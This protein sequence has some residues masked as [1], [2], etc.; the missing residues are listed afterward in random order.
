MHCGE[1]AIKEKYWRKAREMEYE[2]EE[3]RTRI[4]FYGLERMH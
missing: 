2:D 1:L 3:D 4:S